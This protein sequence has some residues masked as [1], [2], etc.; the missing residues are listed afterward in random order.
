MK[1]LFITVP[2]TCGVFG[3]LLE[4]WNFPQYS[5]CIL[6]CR[7]FL[8]LFQPIL[9]RLLTRSFSKSEKDHGEIHDIHKHCFCLL[10]R[11]RDI[12]TIYIAINCLKK[13]KKTRKNSH[14]AIGYKLI[15]RNIV[16]GR[17]SIMSRIRFLQSISALLLLVVVRFT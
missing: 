15:F 8:T 7:L 10:K 3:Y 14:A 16:D 6:S 5:A 9:G 2:G 4:G 13:K 12:T 11:L 17:L 1:Y